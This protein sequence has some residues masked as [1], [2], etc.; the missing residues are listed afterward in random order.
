MHSTS[1]RIRILGLVSLTFALCLPLTAQ[2]TTGRILGRVTDSSGAAVAGAAVLVTDTQRGTTR[3]ATTDA[4]GDYAA[5]ELPPG[6]YKIRA[7]AKGFKTVERPQY[8]AG[9]RTGLAG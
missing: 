5:P 7:E 4:S 6:I 3:S 8:R 1:N 9:G 2:T